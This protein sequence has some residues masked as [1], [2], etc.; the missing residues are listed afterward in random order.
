MSFSL[1][2]MVWFFLMNLLREHLAA[3][4]KIP[5]I[6]KLFI[7]NIVCFLMCKKNY[8]QI[9]IANKNKP[10]R[11]V[12]YLSNSCKSMLTCIRKLKIEADSL[13]FISAAQPNDSFIFKECSIKVGKSDSFYENYEVTSNEFE[14]IKKVDLSDAE[15]IVLVNRFGFFCFLISIIF[16]NL[17][18]LIVFPYMIKTPLKIER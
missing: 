7:E 12:G 9:S 6:C 18:C 11:K 14:Y 4:N 17:S 5:F 13:N 8:K 3:H 10:T 2:S 1:S 16:L 15:L